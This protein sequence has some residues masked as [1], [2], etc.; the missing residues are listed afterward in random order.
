MSC[1]IL[2]GSPF[3]SI[4]PMLGSKEKLT[5]S[6][7]IYDIIRHWQCLPVFLHVCK[8]PKVMY[9]MGL[10]A[11]TCPLNRNLL[12]TILMG[13][14]LVTSHHDQHNILWSLVKTEKPCVKLSC[15]Y[16]V[17]VLPQNNKLRGA[18]PPQ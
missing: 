6:V 1:H 18:R 8:S 15:L 7:I 9:M 13:H 14:A 2:Y 17:Q 5:N 11:L 10:M 12:M 3:L 4:L 16:Q